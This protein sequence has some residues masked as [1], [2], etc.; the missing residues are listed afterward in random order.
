MTL[1][2]G[3]QAVFRYTVTEA[4]TATALG[5]GEVPVLATLRVLALAEQATVATVAGALEAGV[6][7]GSSPC[8]CATVTG[9]SPPAASPGW[10]PPPSWGTPAP[11]RPGE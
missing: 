5:S 11:G 8:T 6:T 3:L 2:A 9:W 10:T 1:E 7:T 4:D